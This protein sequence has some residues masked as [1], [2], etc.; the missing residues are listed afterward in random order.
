ML[1]QIIRENLTPTTRTVRQLRGGLALVF[2][3]RRSTYLRIVA[4][5]R[6]VEPGDRE[7]AI[8]RREILAAVADIALVTVGQFE[9]I[10]PRDGYH[11]AEIWVNFAPMREERTEG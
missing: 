11:A 4:A 5:R 1:A 2:H 8:L 9:R 10:E 3:P 6:G 7:L